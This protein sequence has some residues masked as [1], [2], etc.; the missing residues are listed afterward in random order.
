MEKFIKSA[1]CGL[2]C[3]LGAR[4][5]VYA[6]PVVS[7]AFEDL[8]FYAQRLE[9]G[10]ALQQAEVEYKRYIFMQDYSAGTHQTQAFESLAGLYAKNEQWELAAETVQKAILSSVAMGTPETQ[11][12]ELR[13][14]HIFY[15]L[16]EAQNNR[17]KLSENLSVFS[18]INLPDYSAEVKQTAMCASFKNLIQLGLWE[19]ARND[20]E[21]AM[22]A[23]SLLYTEEQAS[24]IRTNLEKIIA[25]KP[26]NQILAGYLSFFPG[27]GQLYA[28]DYKDA[29][30]SFLLNGSLIAVSVYSIVTLDLWTFSLL[31]FNPLIHFMQGNMYNAQKDAYEYNTRRLAVYSKEIMEIIEK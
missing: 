10:G 13:K 30:N 24:V 14:K 16:Q 15:L 12:D 31:E 19:T 11:T 20:F 9:A 8:F 26:K 21:L 5:I 6:S 3:L 18:Y 4:T 25:F 7:D 2:L 1:F 17:T 23:N 27:L 28:G 29:L 22:E